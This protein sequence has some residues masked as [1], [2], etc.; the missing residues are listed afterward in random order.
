MG[1]G[2]A[3]GGCRATYRAT[4]PER[5]TTG[6]ARD[7]LVNFCYI[8]SLC[9][10]ETV[11]CVLYGFNTLKPYIPEEFRVPGAVLVDLLVVYKSPSFSITQM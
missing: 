5:I 6:A 1:D 10:G 2:R 9:Q 11:I 4:Y 3:A 8:Q 7:E